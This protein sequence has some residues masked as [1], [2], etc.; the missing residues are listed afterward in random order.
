MAL[1]LNGRDREEVMARLLELLAQ[2]N[3]LQERN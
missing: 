2:R 3:L 1:A